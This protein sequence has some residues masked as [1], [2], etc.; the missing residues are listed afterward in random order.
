MPRRP[1][2]HRGGESVRV[3]T[4][5]LFEIPANT[6]DLLPFK[7]LSGSGVLY[8]Q[9]LQH[10]IWENP[11]EFT[12]EPLF[13]VAQTPTVAG[14]G[15]PDIVALDQDGRVVVIE[16]KRAVER[17]QLAQ[18]LEYAGWAKA[19]NLD[20][21][22]G[23]YHGGPQQ[24]FDDWQEFTD[25]AHLQLVNPYPRLA[26][27]ARDFDKRTSAA[28]SFLEDHGVPLTR[29]PVTIYE[30]Q[31]GRRLIDV[32]TGVEPNLPT[33]DSEAEIDHTKIDGRRVRMSD[34]VEADLVPPGTSLVWNRPQLGHEYTATVTPAGAIKLSD[35][36][37]FSTP[38]KA[39]MEAAGIAALDGW[40]AWRVGAADGKSLDDLRRALA[41]SHAQQDSEP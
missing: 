8:E 33:A 12:G 14:G 35:G 15:K 19:T 36:R 18:C 26:L 9:E 24:F 38:S 21:L 34:L 4:I 6:E 23:M 10:L 39:G 25:S 31:G 40:L 27:F 22:A 16:I 32:E 28:L 30:D 7:R 1:G 13:R 5:A 41:V 2:Q 3:P 17:R 29:I 20:E 37:A 11:E